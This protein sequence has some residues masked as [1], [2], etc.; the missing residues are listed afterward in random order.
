MNDDDSLIGTDSG[1]LSIYLLSRLAKAA[2]T[3]LELGVLNEITKNFKGD[4]EV[5]IK[6]IKR[7]LITKCLNG[8][9]DTK[10]DADAFKDCMSSDQIIKLGEGDV[11]LP[12]N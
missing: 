6:A 7:T 2:D 3:K 11:D 10:V 12:D 4:T 8:D 9:N 5:V 1:P